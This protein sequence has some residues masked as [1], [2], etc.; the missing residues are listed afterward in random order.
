MKLRDYNLLHWKKNDIA[1]TLTIETF[2]ILLL[3]I[4]MTLMPPKEGRKNLI[5]IDI[6]DEIIWVAEL[7]K[8]PYTSYSDAKII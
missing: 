3:N 2:K 1:K 4:D 8:L 7:P 6:N 5:A